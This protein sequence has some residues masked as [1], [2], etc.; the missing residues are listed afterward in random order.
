MPETPIQTAHPDAAASPKKASSP[1]TSALPL[2]L[3]EIWWSSRGQILLILFLG[4][5]ASTGLLLI[6]PNQYRAESR[7]IVLPPR[8]LPEARTE[9]LSVATVS[10][11]L[12]SPSILERVHETLNQQRTA[13]ILARSQPGENPLSWIGMAPD[14]LTRR[15]QNLPQE[16]LSL[17]DQQTSFLAQLLSQ[18]S[19]A[20]VTYLSSP[21]SIILSE[22]TV[23]DLAKVLSNA[24][25]VDQRTAVDVRLSP[26]IKLIATGDHPNLA[27][28][29]ANTWASVFENSYDLLSTS[30]TRRQ[31]ESILNQQR[32]SESELEQAQNAVIEFKRQHNLELYLRQIEQYTDDYRDISRQLLAR[33]NTLEA[34]K[35][36]LF[37]LQAMIRV[38]E[39]DNEWIG[40]MRTNQDNTTQNLLG[41]STYQ[42][43][44]LEGSIRQLGDQT[45]RT[46]NQLESALVEFNRV[47]SIQ[48]VELALG[49]RD[50]AKTDYTEA[51]T[52]LSSGRI[53]L[54]T[55]VESLKNLQVQVAATTPT[56]NLMTSPSA[57][58]LTLLNL[59]EQSEVFRF[60][61]EEIHPQWL[62]KVEELSKLE[63]EMT[64]LKAEVT[65]LDKEIQSR[66][67]R[68]R[69]AQATVDQALISNE[70]VRDNLD[71]WKRAHEELFASY[72]ALTN[73]T[74]NTARNLALVEEEVR[75]LESSLER[76][77]KLIDDL[78]E[79]YNSAAAEQ[80][81][82]ETRQRAIQRR[83]ELLFQKLQDAQTAIA[84]E[85]SDI[86][87]AARAVAPSRHFFPR[88]SLLL[89]AMTF[90]V[91]IFALGY[92]TWT[93]RERLL[94]LS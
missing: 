13:I 5:I 21:R 65:L 33:R 88:R 72:V 63:A 42:N 15:L 71:R 70:L 12:G 41:H 94:T 30:K 54:D 84:E 53:R 85:V 61:R 64:V 93:K 6:F 23:D 2:I 92:A 39:S 16:A 28:L 18:L 10:E 91:F 29:M 14:A 79:I 47:S 24:T 31:Y 38:L 73:D 52:R 27:Q 86:T 32:L 3:L 68:Y 87:I 19:P 8:F 75:N 78:Q 55:L 82:L 1:Q 59:E 49:K 62:S 50:Q 35:G 20:E 37:Q 34:Q 51:L 77:R 56:I 83:A 48:P 22:F 57:D 36:Q 26:L 44:S 11:L 58:A 74:F 81:I 76:T 80:N 69:E 45:I 25:T 90:L 66:E 17:N 4:I 60:G 9:P 89:P 43:A 40:T 67:V 46:R 7:V